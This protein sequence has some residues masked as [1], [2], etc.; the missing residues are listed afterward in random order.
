MEICN[1]LTIDALINKAK[2]VNRLIGSGR[3]ELHYQKCL[4]VELRKMGI[5]TATEDPVPVYYHGVMV[6]QGRAD[7][8]IGRC[9]IE[10]KAIAKPPSAAGRQLQDYIRYNNRS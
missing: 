8:I 3:K 9:C 4:D 7:I 10:L 1:G 5:P 2:E 6:W